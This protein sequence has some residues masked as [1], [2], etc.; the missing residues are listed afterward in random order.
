[1]RRKA[2]GTIRLHDG[3][4][5]KKGRRFLVESPYWD[6]KIYPDPHKFDAYRFAKKRDEPGEDNKWHYVSVQP[7][8]M[9]FGL[10]M[11]ACP[12]EY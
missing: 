1:M 8:F 10:G 4:E 7:E 11:Y 6:P 5:I 2:L 12:G 3:F 9:G